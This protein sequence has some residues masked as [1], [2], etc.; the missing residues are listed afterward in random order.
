MDMTKL[1]LK[2][3][4]IVFNKTF[5]K[6]SIR[7]VST[8]SKNYILKR[9]K[10]YESFHIQ[11]PKLTEEVDEMKSFFRIKLFEKSTYHQNH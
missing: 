10:E 1:W 2:D 8:K 7:L 6:D 11:L 3:K 5:R 4:S 9:Y